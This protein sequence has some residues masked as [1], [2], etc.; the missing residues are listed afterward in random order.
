MSLEKVKNDIV[1]RRI[2]RNFKPMTSAGRNEQEYDYRYCKSNLDELKDYYIVV[3]KILKYKGNSLDDFG[4]NFYVYDKDGN[5][6][7][8]P[9]LQMKC[10]ESIKSIN[11]I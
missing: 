6:I 11:D 5:Y 3:S 7:D 1:H 9:E 2:L 10:K 4:L 8:D